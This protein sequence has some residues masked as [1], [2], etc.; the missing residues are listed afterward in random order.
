MRPESHK[1]LRAAQSMPTPKKT[2]TDQHYAGA[3]GRGRETWQPLCLQ[4]GPQDNAVPALGA[5]S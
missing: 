4:G 3:Q 2:T 1:S 5:V